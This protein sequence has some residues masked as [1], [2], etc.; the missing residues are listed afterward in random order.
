M[1]YN[2]LNNTS[3]GTILIIVLQFTE[4]ILYLGSRLLFAVQYYHVIVRQIV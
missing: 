1:F 2:C 4:T 3:Y